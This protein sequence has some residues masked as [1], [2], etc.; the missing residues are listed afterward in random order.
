MKHAGESAL[1]TLED[2]LQQVR[3]S[4]SLIEKK[5]GVFY[6]K[7]A[8]FLHFHEDPAGLFADLRVGGDW[9]RFPVRTK[10]EQRILLSFLA[11]DE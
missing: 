11:S 6:R 7:S 8:A 4:K 3:K 5:R 2:L 10:K 9:K 1:D